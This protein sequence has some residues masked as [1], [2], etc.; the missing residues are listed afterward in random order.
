MNIL[1]LVTILLFAFQV[2]AGSKAQNSQKLCPKTLSSLSKSSPELYEKAVRVVT[3]TDMVATKLEEISKTHKVVAV[4]GSSSLGENTKAYQEVFK[5]VSILAEQKVAIIT[6]GGPG[7]MDAANKAAFL[8]YRPS[9][10]LDLVSEWKPHPS[11]Y[12]THYLKVS[13]L[14]TRKQMFQ[15]YSK[16]IIVAEGGLGTL[17]E[18]F[19]FASE[20][21]SKGKKTQDKPIILLGKRWRKLE[22]HLRELFIEEMGA[23]KESHLRYWQIADTAE[24]A[25]EI[26][27]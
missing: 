12:M 7:I 14:S 8:M 23:M 13:D 3:E 26:L 24:Q 27:R 2:E 5:L 20:I 15:H 9:I 17:D 22:A 16:A 6:G 10:G 19:H 11:T 1:S 4:V 25:L 18:L 21:Y